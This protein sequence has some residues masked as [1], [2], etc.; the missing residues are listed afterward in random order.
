MNVTRAAALIPVLHCMVFPAA[1]VFGPASSTFGTPRI[2]DWMLPPPLV[3]GVS[4]KEPVLDTA[5]LK[6]LALRLE[7]PYSSLKFQTYHEDTF[8]PSFGYG[9]DPGLGDPKRS[10]SPD[11]IVLLI[12]T[13]PLNKG[14][15]YAV[16]NDGKSEYW[17]SSQSGWLYAYTLAGHL[18]ALSNP[19]LLTNSYLLETG[20]RTFQDSQYV[21]L[22]S[23]SLDVFWKRNLVSTGWGAQYVYDN[24]IA[25]PGSSILPVGLGYYFDGLMVA[26]MAADVFGNGARTVGEKIEG[27]V[28]ILIFSYLCKLAFYPWE[29]STLP[30]YNTVLKSGYSV[31][32]PAAWSQIR[33]SLVSP[34]DTVNVLPMSH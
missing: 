17:R 19:S 23:R 7:V 33:D 1:L 31:P 26:F 21:A 4:L 18:G 10:H 28:G 13:L 3:E 15:G 14:E 6:R 24:P 8:N 20:E 29:K 30:R 32:K 34:R 16:L 5:A 12:D 9:I 22:K 27:A 25:K 11:E 2:F